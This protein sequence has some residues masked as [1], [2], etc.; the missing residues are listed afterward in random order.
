MNHVSALVAEQNGGQRSGD[1]L[2]KI[3]NAYAVERP[4]HVAA[5]SHPPSAI[6][7]A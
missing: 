4:C 7:D 2:T 3:N 1:K 5:S 6:H